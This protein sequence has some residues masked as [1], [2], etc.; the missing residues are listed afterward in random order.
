MLAPQFRHNLNGLHAGILR[1]R[2]GHHLKGLGKG[3]HA[4]RVHPRH[5]H[6]GILEAEAG[7]DLGRA[8]AGDEGALLD[9]APNDALRVVDGA[10]GLLQH[11]V[12]GSAEEDRHGLAGILDAGE[13]DHL[14]AAAGHDDV[15]DVV[16]RAELVGRHG[17]GMGD[18]SAAQGAADEF[19][20]GAFNVGDDQNAHLGQKVQTEFVVGI[21]QDTLL[22]QHDICAAFLDLLA[23]TQNVLALVA[24][25]AVHGGVVGNDDVVVHVGLG[26]R[27]AELNQGNLGLGDLG[28]SPGALGAALGK[29]QTV[30]QF[31]IVDGSAHLLDHANV[32][33][34]DVGGRRGIVAEEAED[35]IDGDG[36]EEVGVLRH[37]LGGEAGVDG[38]DEG[39]A[40]GQVDGAGHVA[41]GR[42][43]EV[44]GL[45]EGRGDGRGVDALGQQG[46]AGVEEGPGHDDDGGGAVAGLNVLRLG[47]FDEHLGGRV[48]DVH[49]GEDGGTV[50]A[51]EDLAVGHLH[52]LVH[53]AG[54]QGGADGV[55]HGL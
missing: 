11:Q 42:G 41:H 21:S 5:P 46:R 8:A 32:A 50:V 47:Q 14:V 51:D 26:G 6:G 37:D 23:L 31:G 29:D 22:D 53:P 27:E 17:I 55:G 54:S 36:G 39:V 18:G 24:K 34:V 44:G 4:V 45:H 25:D 7:L 49:F 28:G 1:E 13:L 16:G 35:G 38:R 10:V 40:V 52:Q 19:D 9:Q 15:A 43:G 20:V 2:E 30:D 12:V 33:Q 3:L 48:E